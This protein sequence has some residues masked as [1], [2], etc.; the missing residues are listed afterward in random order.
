MFCAQPI[1]TH[2]TT[3]TYATIDLALHCGH[4]DAHA[5]S[6]IVA[7]HLK[8]AAESSKCVIYT[9]TSKSTQLISA[10]C[11][12]CRHLHSTSL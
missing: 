1:H 4:S 6:F 3:T 9:T 7:Q 12:G 10:P 5:T 8:P 11:N 2:T